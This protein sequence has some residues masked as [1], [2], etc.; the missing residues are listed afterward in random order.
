MIL[1]AFFGIAFYLGIIAFYIASMWKI[2]TKAEQPGWACLIPFYNIYQLN[3]IG[4]GSNINLWLVF[5]SSIITIPLIFILI[6]L[7]DGKS[8][9]F[10]NEV[11][12][13]SSSLLPVLLILMF[14]SFIGHFIGMIRIWH[15]VSKAFGQDAGF[16]AGLILV[17]FVFIPLLAFGKKYQY[18]Y[19]QDASE[20]ITNHLII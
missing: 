5:G 17:S 16:T 9:T 18:I 3:K 12:N 19:K 20:D 6:V 8:I 11:V 2:H 13:I 4:K 15:G 1:F 10:D 7:A 14:I